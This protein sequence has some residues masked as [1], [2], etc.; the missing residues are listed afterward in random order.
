MKDSPVKPLPYYSTHARATDSDLA[1][2][3]RATVLP[4]IKRRLPMHHLCGLPHGWVIDFVR[5]N[6]SK[7]PYY[8]RTDIKKFYPSV[9]HID[10]LVGAQVAYRDLLGL[11]Y[12]P[13]SFTHKYLGALNL[14]IKSLPL[15]TRGI[16][17]NSPISCLL[18]PLMLVPL[19]LILKNIG[20]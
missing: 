4:L 20:T 19:W 8:L 17:L 5:S 16:A 14:W 9:R 11:P 3:L 13:K 7:Y 15:S 18:A 2:S 6:S 12:V 10:I 1:A